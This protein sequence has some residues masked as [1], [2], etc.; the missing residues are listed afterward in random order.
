MTGTGG[1]PRNVV[2]VVDDQPEIRRMAT[3]VLSTV[4]FGA[5]VAEDG[6][7]GLEC[8]L[9]H[10]HEICLVVSDVLMP[11]MNGLEMVDQILQIEPNAKILMMSAYS[12]AALEIKAREHFAFIRK[13]FLARD[14]I[15][16]I[17]DVLAL[18]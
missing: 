12:N 9:K 6:K 1:K 4:G 3:A 2:L 17:R 8:F 15:Q 18:E 11:L 16:K 10:Q 7:D 5:Q 14:F 13:P